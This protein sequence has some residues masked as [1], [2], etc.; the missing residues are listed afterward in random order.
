MTRRMQVGTPWHV[1][2]LMRSGVRVP[3]FVQEKATAALNGGV[4]CGVDGDRRQ[5]KWPSG[6]QYQ[7]G[8]GRGL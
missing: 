5:C 3:S 2:D 6:A 4:G 8:A 7:K 1:C